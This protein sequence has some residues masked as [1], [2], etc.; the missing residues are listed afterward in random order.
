MTSTDSS[1]SSASRRS[2]QLSPQLIHS[3]S[4]HTYKSSQSHYTHPYSTC[5]ANLTT[6]P[7][8]LAPVHPQLSRG[9]PRR[10]V[11]SFSEPTIASSSSPLCASHCNILPGTHSA[12]GDA[13]R[14]HKN[15]CT[16]QPAPNPRAHHNHNHFP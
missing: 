6:V 1:L 2:C 12:M 13:K 16:F 11:Q 3:C 14:V 5:P 15:T 9:V 8:A 7:R 4:S 10:R